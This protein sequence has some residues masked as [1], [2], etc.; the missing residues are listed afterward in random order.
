MFRKAKNIDSAFK[1]IKT[2]S[3]VLITGVTLLSGFIVHKSLDTVKTLQSKI[4]VLA[5]G[6]AL[7]AYSSDRK[8]NIPI[9]AKD[10]VKVFHQFFFTLSPDDKLIKSNINK[11]LY[12]ADETAKKEYDN[13]RE[14]NYYSNVISGNVSQAVIVDSIVLDLN[15]YPHVFR[16]F[17]KQEITRPTSVVV[18]SLITE[19]VLRNVARSENNSH[20][21][22]IEKWH[23]I[24]NADLTIKNR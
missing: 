10:H 3:L 17:G 7:E 5:N 21:F 2:F 8:D 14:Q 9:E 23:T 4:Y 19:G 22:L 20:G 15:I 16:F 18:R 24:E 6:K 11:A 13:L 1:H 12:L